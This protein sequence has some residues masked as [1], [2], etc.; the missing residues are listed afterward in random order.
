MKAYQRWLC[1]CLFL[2]GIVFFL[3]GNLTAQAATPIVS[4]ET[5]SESLNVSEIDTFEFYGEVGDR[6]LIDA[7]VVSGVYGFDTEIIL[8]DPDFSDEANTQPG[9]DLLDHVLQK[10]GIYNIFVQDVDKNHTGSYKI[11]LLNLTRGP[12][13]SAGD[14]DGG[15]IASG[16]TLSGSLAVSDMDGFQ[17]YGEAGDRVLIDADVVSGV[18]G[19]DTVII[20]IAP[21][22]TTEIDT[23]SGGDLLDHTLDQTGT[24]TIVAQDAGLNHT[25]SYKITLIKLPGSHS[26]PDDSNGGLIAPGDVLSGALAVSDMDGFQFYGKLND[27]VMINVDVVSG[28]YGFNTEIILIDPD[29]LDEADTKPGGDYLDHNLLKTGLYTIMVQDAGLNH[30]G[31]YNISFNKLPNTLRPGIYNP[32]PA[33]T[34]GVSNDPTLSWD[35]VSGATGYDVFFGKDVVEPLQKV[36]NNVSG[37]S[38][39]LSLL[40]DSTIYYWT[41]VAHTPSGDIPGT[42]NWFGT[43]FKGDFE[44]D[45]DVDGSDL[46][47]FAADF[48]RTD[49]D[50]GPPCEGDFDEDNDVDG[51]DLAVFAADFGRTDCPTP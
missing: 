39:P 28:V 22:F 5:M 40:N 4:G 42:V 46:A 14:S 32:D 16:D 2:F 50:T 48:G 24:Y 44:P 19:F 41:V 1:K 27:R 8:I 51:S 37:T 7:D 43:H 45:G 23:L 9:G 33:A 10:S 11:T 34:C 38:F 18:Y 13:N 35:A 36:G 47:V 31:T 6:V 30:T 26:S 20:L 29:F 17:F 21:D 3:I 25:G 12:M 49:C 15:P